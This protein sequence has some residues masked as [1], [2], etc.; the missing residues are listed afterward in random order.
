MSTDNYN[1]YFTS[2]TEDK[3]PNNVS[4]NTQSN[5]DTSPNNINNNN[6]NNNI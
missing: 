4:T 1:S 6:Y 2:T 5:V 3:K